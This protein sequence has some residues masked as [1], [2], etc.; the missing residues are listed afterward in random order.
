M[1]DFECGV[2]DAW[3]AFLACGNIMGWA[4]TSTM[5]AVKDM[6]HQVAAGIQV[7]L[8]ASTQGSPQ[9]GDGDK[10]GGLGGYRREYS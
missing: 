3:I 4:G 7:A 5:A 6:G 2:C 8:T 1:R 9:K 10:G